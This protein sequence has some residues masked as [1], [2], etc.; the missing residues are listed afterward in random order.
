MNRSLLVNVDRARWPIP[1]A[2]PHFPAAFAP[3]IQ[4]FNCGIPTLLLIIGFLTTPIDPAGVSLREF[5]AWV[6]YL[7]AISDDPDLRGKD[8]FADLDPHQKT[9]LSDDFGMGVPI[10]WLINRLQCKGTQSGSRYRDLQLGEA[11]PPMSGAV[12]QKR[13]IT[14]PSWNTGQRLACGLR[15]GIHGGAEQSSLRVVD[16]VGD[17]ELVVG[18]G[19]LAF[20]RDAIIRGT[21]ARSLRLAGFEA[22]SLTVSSPY[23]PFPLSRPMTGTAGQARREIVRQMRDLA[24]DELKARTTRTLFKSAGERYRGRQIN[25]DLPVPVKSDG[26]DIRS[27]RVRH[28]VNARF[29]NELL[30]RPPIEDLSQDAGIPWR[31]MVG[32]INTRSSRF[33]A[34]L[35]I[36]SLFLTEIDLN[37]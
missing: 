31:Q 9:I 5:W 24:T 20:A 14:F 1:P 35:R 26:R 23:G 2:S 17:E 16:P 34:R 12:A 33:T 21:Y 27:V 30:R 8:L 18:E 13:S 6:R 19:H 25:F 32:T 28:G 7:H 4:I 36:G 10:C 11:G 3:G 37:K 29:L 15:I 22:A